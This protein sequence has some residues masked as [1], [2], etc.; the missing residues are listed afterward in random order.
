MVAR[1]GKC[2]IGNNFA[3]NNSVKGNP[4]ACIFFVDKAAIL[5]IGENVGLTQTVIRCHHQIT[6]GDN[7]KIGRGTEIYDTDFHALDPKIRSSKEDLKNKIKKAVII[8]ENVFIGAYS[9]ILKGVTIGE[10]SI[11][12]AG[13]IVTK[14]I[15]SNQIWA[16][17][18]A[19]F[20]RNL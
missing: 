2:T 17:N 14:S 13:S 19:K 4:L 11:V 6:V 20:I 7:V 8:E 1:G 15:P 10:N 18:P 9:I 16:G 12:G 3:M 5:Q